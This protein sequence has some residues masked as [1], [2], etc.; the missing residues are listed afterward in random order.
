MRRRDFV[1]AALAA[2]VSAKNL[3]GQ[4]QTAPTQVAPSAPPPT[5]PG[6]APPPAPGPVPW[7]R[8]LLE[9]KPLSLPALV[10]D[11][12]AQTTNYFF[13]ERQMSTLRQLCEILLPPLGGYP[14]AL[15]TGAPEFLDFLISVS[16]PDRQRVY[17]EGLDWLDA[18]AHAKFGVGF[19]AA[20]EKQADALIRPWLRTWMTDHPPQEQHAHFI[21]V[22]HSDIRTA[23]VNSEAWHQAETAEGKEPGG[24]GLY[25][26]PVDPD[27][28]RR[29]LPP[30]KQE[31]RV[32]RARVA[33][34]SAKRGLGLDQQ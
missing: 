8:G 29:Y 26:Y 32:A 12:V 7:M 22:A 19:D 20:N 14:G 9:A 27:V 4:A 11:H 3:L 6:A 5:P 33:N 13:S 21:N 30:R 31:A 34:T 25:W 24:V 17:V 28:N 2:S 10:P 16:P 1:K 18:E 23:T 15:D